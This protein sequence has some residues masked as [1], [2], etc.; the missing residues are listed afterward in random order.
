MVVHRH[1]GWRFCSTEIGST[2]PAWQ[3]IHGIRG[4]NT[5]RTWSSHD[6][7]TRPESRGRPPARLAGSDAALTTAI[8]PV[9]AVAMS[10]LVLGETVGPAQLIGMACVL[11]AVLA[12]AAWDRR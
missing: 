9:A 10:A 4:V 6:A 11:A 2:L 8:L 5:H 7:G 3:S 1:E 12:G